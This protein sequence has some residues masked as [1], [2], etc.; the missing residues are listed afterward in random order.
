MINAGDFNKKIDIV[1]HTKM[2]D[3]AGFDTVSDVII[4]SAWA[5]VNT[6]RGFTLIAN[7]TNFEQA[8]TAFLIRKPTVD[9]KRK[10]F[11][12]FDGVDW[13]I[14][15]LNNIDE[16]NTFVELQCKQVNNENRGTG[17]SDGEV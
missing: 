15:Y 17:G 11:V 1:R 12:R 9:I 2:T 7:G 16:A 10:D 13:R 8:T 5:K 4:A 6:T 3:A 14:E